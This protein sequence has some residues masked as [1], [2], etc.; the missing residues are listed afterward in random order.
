MRDRRSHIV[1]ACVPF[2]LALAPPALAGG[3]PAETVV[4]VNSQSAESRRV[5]DHYVR[6]RRIPRSH[7]LEVT[8][9]A[10]LE[11]PI[12][13]FVRDVA[14]PLRAFLR[15]RALEDRVKF[16]VLTQGMPIRAATPAGHVSTTA[17]LALLDTPHCGAPQPGVQ[18][19]L[20]SPAYTG[21]LPIP[22]NVECPRFLHVTALLSTTAD[23]AVALVDRSVASDGTAPAGALFLFQDANGN[24]GTRNAQY[25]A[26]RRELEALGATTEHVRAG[27]DVAVNRKRVMGYMAGGS[28]SALTAA[29]VSSNEYLPGALCDH[30]QS[31]GAVPQNFDPDPKRHSQFPVTHMVRAGVTG[32]HGAVA[33]PFTVAFPDP[34]LFTAYVQ[35]ATLAETFSARLPIAYWQNLVLGDPLCAPFAVR[36]EVT[37]D[38]AP[39]EPWSKAVALR[40]RAPG[41]KR[42]DVYVDGVWTSGDD[43]AETTATVDTRRFAD[44]PREVLVEATGAGRWE[45]RGWTTLDVAFANPELRV[46][47]A[48]GRIGADL[49]ATLSRPPRDGER[50]ALAVTAGGAPVAGSS[51]VDGATLVFRPDGSLPDGDLRAQVSG[52]AESSS[53]ALERAAR[54]VSVA[55][56]A[57]VA[58]GEPFVLR[59]KVARGDVPAALWRGRVEAR[60]A[61]P[62]VRLVATD[63]T[64]SAAGVVEVPL[65]FT[66]AG[67]V[68]VRVSLADD[69]PAATARIS[70]RPGPAKIATSPLSRVALGQPVDVDVVV[71]DAFGNRV[72]DF[73]G[74]LSLAV[75]G[76]ALAK[77]P[78]PVRITKADRGRGVFRDVLFTRGGNVSLVL[79]DVAG[80]AMSLPSEG[81]QATHGAVTAWLV[82]RGGRA[83]NVAALVAPDPAKD[84][85]RDGAVSGGRL[86]RRVRTRGDDVQFPTSAAKDGEAAVATTFVRAS[87]A[88]KVRLLGAAPARLV[89][90]V[91]GRVVHDGPPKATDSRGRRDPLAD[92]ALDEGTHRL[93]VIATRTGGAAAFSLEID[94]GAGGH[95]DGV[96]VEPAANDDPPRAFTVSGRVRR[97]TSG[98]AGAKV[99]V[100]RADGTE[101]VA[102]SS[103]DGT[104]HVAGLPS[105]EVAVRAE[106]PK[107]LQ[108]AT[109]RVTFDG[110]H[111]VDVDFVA[112]DETPPVVRLAGVPPRFGKRIVLTPIVEDDDAVRDVRLLVDGAEVARATAA[113]WRLAADVAGVPRGRREV[114][115]TATD[116]S[117]NTGRSAPADVA[118]IDDTK[119]PSVKVSGIAPDAAVKR[120]VDVSAAVTDDIPVAEVRFRLDGTDL[121]A[122]PTAPPWTCELDPKDLADGVHTLAVV[123]KDL[124]G[125]ETTV[126]VRFRTR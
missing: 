91:D 104:W 58:A 82:A 41:A 49:R 21:A 26:A 69:G 11:T 92:V 105:G 10:S 60:L 119:G 121:G 71:M 52:A 124:D 55:A 85:D 31:F 68:D 30:L 115:V 38:G 18:P 28:Y 23:E 1:A 76:D 54:D 123:A 53:W 27:A 87:S 94:D 63:A 32:V 89:V 22:P 100:R 36:P 113:P 45:P 12:A 120:K 122:V 95:P 43:G 39:P 98:V 8:C 35:G 102:T 9:T 114:V 65:R 47:D 19:P 56:P 90:L 72:E 20:R 77:V 16:V 40:V 51:V 64:A 15:L 6:A 117:G 2:L 73:E 78:G 13:D 17:A 33:E 34:D 118:L 44:G 108:P 101:H 4:L 96:F 61:D 110:A 37:V 50:P 109:R 66:R 62:P 83:E 86:F 107:G 99:V 74:E 75:P 84:A 67:D 112:K 103:A 59:L 106:G 125:N 5:A 24:A 7:V 93:T 25:D 3:G 70:V 57:S 29:G 116:A 81:V 88:R 79:S 126:E 46:L 48:P 80:A 42:I 111:A 97:G 14:D